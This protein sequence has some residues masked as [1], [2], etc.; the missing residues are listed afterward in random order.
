MKL[1]TNIADT[2]IAINLL[3]QAERAIH[4]CRQFFRDFIYSGQEKDAEIKVS[5]LKN[6]NKIS[7]VKN[8]ERDHVI[9]QRL[10]TRDV[11]AWLNKIPWYTNDFPITEATI[12]SFCLDGLLLFNPDSS[13]GHIYLL[14]DGPECFR[15][16]YRLFW[17]YLA[18]VIGERKGCFVHSS[19]LVRDEKA[20]L[21]LGDSGAGKSSL[22]RI[23]GGSGVFSD[24][25][26]ILCERNGDYLVFPSPYHQ[27]DPLKGLDKEVMGLNARV[28]GLYFLTKDDRVYL[29]RISKRE[30]ISL[31]INR[32]IHF[33]R[34]LS[35]R[36]KSLLFELFIDLCDKIPYYNLHFSLDDDIWDVIDH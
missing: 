22:A 27:I 23:C 9:E 29:E 30:A 20:Y 10:S 11:I 31:I 17:M 25:S 7:L 6:D 36:A 13:D 2:H 5:I 35:T 16:I 33:F 24:D 32:H 3:G 34:H 18:Q 12:S 26:P 8:G 21:F 14:K 1:T 28:E 15:P 4:L 19:A